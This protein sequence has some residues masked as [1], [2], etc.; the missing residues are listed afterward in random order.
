MI[1]VSI[2]PELIEKTLRSGNKIGSLIEVIDGLPFNVRLVDAKM[3]GAYLR[4][5]FSQPTVPDTELSDLN[6]VLKARQAIAIEDL[7]AAKRKDHLNV[8]VTVER[9]IG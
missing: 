5:Y 9:T 3:D 8:G 7:E 2:T 6:I 1:R 4:L